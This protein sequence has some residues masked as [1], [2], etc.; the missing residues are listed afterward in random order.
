M[1]K[2]MNIETISAVHTP[3]IYK[4]SLQAEVRKLENKKAIEMIKIDEAKTYG[5]VVGY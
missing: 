3:Y 2:K 1:Q 4:I 5:Q